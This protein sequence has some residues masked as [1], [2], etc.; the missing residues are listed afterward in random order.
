MT[1]TAKNK[2]ISAATADA[3]VWQRRKVWGSVGMTHFTQVTID[4]DVYRFTLDQPRQGQWT[5]R[6][7]VNGGFFMYRD[8]QAV[9]TL[10]GMKAEVL[11][12]VT[13]L[14]DKAAGK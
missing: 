4:K 3:I 13:E 10:A 7:W 6:G 2:G 9:N 8:N 1:N 12:V 11:R 5:A 14:R